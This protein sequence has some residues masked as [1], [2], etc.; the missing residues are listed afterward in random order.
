MAENEKKKKKKKEKGNNNN[1]Y[2][3]AFMLVEID[4]NLFWRM[5]ILS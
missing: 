5:H 2:K 3:N 4:T 1:T